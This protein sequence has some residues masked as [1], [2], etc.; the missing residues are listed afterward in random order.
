M[1]NIY[2]IENYRCKGEL[3]TKSSCCNRLAYICLQDTLWTLTGV[4]GEVTYLLWAY[5]LLAVVMWFG[6]YYQLVRVIPELSLYNTLTHR[7]ISLQ[8][9]AQ[10]RSVHKS[11]HQL[12]SNQK[13]EMLL[14]WI[15]IFFSTGYES[16]LSFLFIELQ[17]IGK[18]MPL[19][20]WNV[21]SNFL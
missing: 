3:T 4:S 5:P 15:V 16:V 19:C 12:L 18:M 2:S 10:Q 13:R 1:K 11:C 9:C 8:V 21:L 14:L 7:F 6:F 17:N 20:S